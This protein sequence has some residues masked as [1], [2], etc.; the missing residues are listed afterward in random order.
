MKRQTTTVK[1][2]TYIHTPRKKHCNVLKN[3]VDTTRT[4]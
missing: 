2:H 1:T 4:S 3:K